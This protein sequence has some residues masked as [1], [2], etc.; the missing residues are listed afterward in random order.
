MGLVTFGLPLLLQ[1]VRMSQNVDNAM[2]NAPR[3]STIRLSTSC[4]CRPRTCRPNAALDLTGLM[5][6]SFELS[7]ITCG[8]EQLAGL[9]VRHKG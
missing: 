4:H 2:F 1:V 7:A 3:H 9:R 5:R 8:S 6:H